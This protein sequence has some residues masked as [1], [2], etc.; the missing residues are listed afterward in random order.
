MQ[1]VPAL[2]WVFSHPLCPHYYSSKV[3][4]HWRVMHCTHRGTTGK[5]AEGKH[6]RWNISSINNALGGALSLSYQSW[7]FSCNKSYRYHKKRKKKTLLQRQCYSKPPLNKA[8]FFFRQPVT[9]SNK[10]NTFVV[11]FL[12]CINRKKLNISIRI[13]SHLMWLLWILFAPSET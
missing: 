9:T 8:H 13:Y 10:P 1:P 7:T 4:F 3:C 2:T 12:S 11:T 6:I 5:T